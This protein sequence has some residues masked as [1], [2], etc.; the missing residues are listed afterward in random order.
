MKIKRKRN[1]IKKTL[2]WEVD[3]RGLNTSC[4]TINTDDIK[5]K[6]KKN[7]KKSTKTSYFYRLS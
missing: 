3:L 5:T 1:N 7:S 6:R 2:V 4:L